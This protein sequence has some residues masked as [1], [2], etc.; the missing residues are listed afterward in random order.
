MTTDTPRPIGRIFRFIVGLALIS[1][2]AQY[3]AGGG[4]GFILR[5]FAVVAS[6]VLI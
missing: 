5:S 2:V 1:S 6:L 3:W 4:G